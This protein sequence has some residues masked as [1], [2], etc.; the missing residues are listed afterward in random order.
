MP[1]AGKDTSDKSLKAEGKVQK[2][3]TSKKNPPRTEGFI[4]QKVSQTYLVFFKF[5]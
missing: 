2:E 3:K 5:G 1:C 4:G